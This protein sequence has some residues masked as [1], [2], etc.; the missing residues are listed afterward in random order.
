MSISP[1][2]EFSPEEW[3]R[4]RADTELTLDREEL[5]QLRGLNEPVSLEEVI[6]IYL[7]MA[8]LLD[9]YVQATQRLYDAT[10]SFLGH[11][12]DKVPYVIGLAGSVAVGKSTTARILEALLERLPSEPQVSLITTD[13]FLYP[14]EVLEARGL[15]NRKGFPE[16][17][18]LPRLLQFVSDVKAGRP[19]VHCPIYSHLHYDVIEGEFLV[20]DRPDIVIVEGLN[21][22]QT[23]TGDARD[24]SRVFVSD[25]FDFTVYVDAAIEDIRRWYV[26]RFL[27]LRHTAFQDPESY[28]HR[29]ADLD[30]DEARALARRIWRDI[31]EVNLVANILPTRERA[32]LIIEKGADHDIEGVRLRKI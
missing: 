22:L 25:F 18:D 21:V 8:R 1:Y 14:N 29:Y 4:L 12:E 28:F 20:V 10:A 27:Q 6:E 23:G 2:I 17:Y 13:G 11:P 7:P 19:E 26:E 32:N 16:T 3:G 30:D 15:M 5:E 31:N 24:G 9:L